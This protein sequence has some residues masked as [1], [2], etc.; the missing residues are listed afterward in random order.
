MATRESSSSSVAS[1]HLALAARAAAEGNYALVKELYAAAAAAGAVEGE[2]AKWALLLIEAGEL[3]EGW[4]LQGQQPEGILSQEKGSQPESEDTGDDFLTFEATPRVDQGKTPST[5]TA[6]IELFRRWFAGR[7]DVYARQWYDARNDRTGYVPVREPLDDR[8]IAQHLEGR[9]TIGQYLLYPDHHVSFAVIDL[10]PTSAALEQARLE[11]TDELGGLGLP[12]LREYASRIV[13]TARELDVPTLLEDTGGAGLHIWIFFAPRVP[14]RRARAFV[15][16]LLWRSG[17]QPASVVVEIF[18]KQ[19]ELTGKGL[20]NLVKLPLGVHQ[21]TLRPSRFLQGESLEPLPELSALRSVCPVDPVIFDRLLNDRVVPLRP[22][23]APTPTPQEPSL[24]TSPLGSPRAL[25][26]ALAAIESRK[27]VAEAVDRVLENCAVLRELARR[28]LEGEPL[29]T[30]GLRCLLYS[31]GLIGRDNPVIEQIF[32]RTGASRKEL[33]RVRRGLQSPVGC[34]RLKEYFP[35]LAERCSC[36]EV[37]EAGYA[38]P[39]LFALSGSPHF[40]RREPLSPVAA[41]EWLGSDFPDT[42]SSKEEL[43]KII[44]RLE[45]VEKILRELLGRPPS[46]PST[47]ESSAPPWEPATE[48]AETSPSGGRS[49]KT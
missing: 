5:D 47:P 32:A 26:E 38:T 46:N 21:A 24:P 37:P 34:R 44:A 8:V 2:R 3:E 7:G 1:G 43:R 39:V 33:E 35:Q 48:A 22:L 9:I 6:L 42:G 17:S 49:P 36:P 20:G 41:D 29:P 11:Q 28:A 31:I 19:D 16:E 23:Q 30:T 13:R 27:P 10:D 18:P 12:A 45:E 40:H 14:A 15:R 25:A 4:R